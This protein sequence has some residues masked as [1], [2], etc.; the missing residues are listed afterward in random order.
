MNFRKTAQEVLA[1]WEC[2]HRFA[3]DLVE[4]AASQSQLAPRDRSALQRLVFAVIRNDRLLAHWAGELAHGKLD[5]RTLRLAKMG[6]AELVLLGDPPHAAVSETVQL[7]GWAKR[8]LNGILRNAD[9]SASDLQAQRANLPPPI[10]WSIP[11][12]LW[13]RWCVQHGAEAAAAF[14]RW[15][16]EPAPVYV[17]LN[18]LKA[19]PDTVCRSPQLQPVTSHPGFWQLEGAMPVEW[20]RDG[21]VYAQDPST[22][23]AVELLNPEPG[24][25]I[26]DA[27]AAPG[28]KSFAIAA[29]TG[30]QAALTAVDS[31][32]ARLRRLERNLHKLGVRATVLA[33]DWTSPDCACPGEFD[34][35]LLDAPCSN[36][37][38]IRRRIDVPHRLQPA[39]FASV[40]QLQGQLL[41]ALAP[42]LAPAGRL[43]Y[44]TCSIDLEEGRLLVDRF[45][46]E[47]PG[48]RKVGESSTRPWIDHVDGT[49]AAAIERTSQSDPS[50]RGNSPNDTI[51]S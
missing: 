2:T 42:R 26:L 36:S 10:Q 38:V 37:G 51:R 40:I 44:S 1:R 19:V 43:V 17:R 21:W 45:L 50:L 25:R 16:H 30:N 4:E 7:A 35:I 12:F 6:L 31:S 15:N 48:F 23:A 47:V 28:G 20:L 46:A 33:A 24:Q 8:I 18:P 5:P 34:R 22:A 29:R 9:R 11:P 39:D 32:P 49:Y 14:C 27:C 41:R 13:E 3:A